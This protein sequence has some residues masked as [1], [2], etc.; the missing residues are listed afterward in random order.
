MVFRC[1]APPPAE[2]RVAS[3]A[4]RPRCGG[5]ASRRRSPPRGRSRRASR[6]THAA[7]SRDAPSSRPAATAAS[8]RC[9]GEGGGQP[10]RH[11]RPRA[12]RSAERS[13]L[14]LRG[15]GVRARR[16]GTGWS[17]HRTARR[18]ACARPWLSGRCG[19]SR[20]P[21]RRRRRRC[22]SAVSCSGVTPATAATLTSADHCSRGSRPVEAELGASAR[23]TGRGTPGGGGRR[24]RPSVG[25]ARHQVVG[26]GPPPSGHDQPADHAAVLERQAHCSPAAIGPTPSATVPG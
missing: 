20:R 7:R 2:G 6:R 10:W 17:A 19:R 15:G 5:G 22:C 18:S 11:G 23:R 4:C 12:A 21:T 26:A 1:R 24:P 13:R 8:G 16:G 3:Q 9:S 25:P 14:V